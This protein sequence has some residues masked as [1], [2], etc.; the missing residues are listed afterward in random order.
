[1]GSIIGWLVAKGLSEKVARLVAMAGL[2][3]TVLALIGGTKCAYDASVIRK[4]EAKAELKQAKRERVADQ[5]LEQQ[6][7]LD[8]ADKQQRQKEIDDATQGIPDQAPSARQRARACV[9]LRRQA[10]ERGQP[11]PAC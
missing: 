8:E 4:H 10:K 11:Q 5:N 2:F 1:M 6:K 3:L 7:R 9:E